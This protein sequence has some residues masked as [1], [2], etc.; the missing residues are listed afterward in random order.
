MELGIIDY[1]YFLQRFRSYGAKKFL[2]VKVGTHSKYFKNKY[3][4]KNRKEII[5]KITRF[6]FNDQTYTGIVVND[7]V[8][9]FNDKIMDEIDGS[10][11]E[12]YSRNNKVPL[13]QIKYSKLIPNSSKIIAIGLNYLDH[14]KE[15]DVKIPDSPLVFSKFSNSI[16]AH[17]DKIVWDNEITK[18]VDFEAELA[19]IIKKE[20]KN[21]S[22]ENAMDA[23]LGYTCANDIS[24]RDLQFG[25]RQWVRGKSLDTFCP[26]GPWAVTADEIPDPHSLNITCKVNNKIMQQSNTKNM[27]FRIDKLIS[28]LS[29][30]FTLYPSDIILTGTPAGVGTFRKPPIYLQDNDE[31]SVEIEGIGVLTNKCQ[32]LNKS[33]E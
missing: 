20:I 3:N 32:V 27:I 16:I 13:D 25:D 24:A 14:A 21:C 8:I 19:V 33:A 2:C 6:C 22:E 15:A 26:L 5:M 9:P 4:R 1:Q 28:F 23:V 7:M 29:K 30:H 10:K 18:Q 12:E 31:I 11:F 17:N